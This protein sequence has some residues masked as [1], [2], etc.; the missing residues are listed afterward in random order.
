MNLE[1]EEVRGVER[2]K[3]V[4]EIHE[5]NSLLLAEEKHKK[6]KG[7]FKEERERE[8]VDMISPPCQD[9]ELQKY[10]NYTSDEFFMN[11]GAR[12]DAALIFVSF[13]HELRC[14]EFIYQFHRP[15]QQLKTFFVTISLC[16]L[17]LL[18]NVLRI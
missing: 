10:P 16:F 7:R 9:S 12:H 5:L 8:D 1:K 3:G 14:I 11:L 18:P 17:C 15:I 13:S 2:R 6:A 4:E